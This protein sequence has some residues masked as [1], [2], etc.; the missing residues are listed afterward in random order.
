MRN[1]YLLPQRELAGVVKSEEEIDLM[2]YRHAP[3]HHRIRRDL[4]DGKAQI[5]L[6]KISQSCRGS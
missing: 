6:C 3:A 4:S 2:L 1:K 5:V